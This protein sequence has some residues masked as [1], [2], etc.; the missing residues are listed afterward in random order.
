M[1]N[2]IFFPEKKKEMQVSALT[3]THLD[4]SYLFN[5][6]CTSQ[7]KKKAM[8][9]PWIFYAYQE[10]VKLH[11]YFTAILYASN[12]DEEKRSNIDI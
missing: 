3:N 12:T 7:K 2:T 4:I 5:T 6:Q 9:L 1:V 8:Q 11:V 10:Q